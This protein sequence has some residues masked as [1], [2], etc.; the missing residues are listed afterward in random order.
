LQFTAKFR[1]WLP[2]ASGVSLAVAL[3][4]LV[5]DLRLAGQGALPDGLFSRWQLWLAM[6]L[7]FQIWT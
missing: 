6:A 5:H 7:L 4:R 1:R 3:W 2:A